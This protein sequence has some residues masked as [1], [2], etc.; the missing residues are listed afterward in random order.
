MRHN[1][2]SV[3]GVWW[4]IRDRARACT[5]KYAHRAAIDKHRWTNWNSFPYSAE[6][7][8]YSTRHV[9]SSRPLCASAV[10]STPAHMYGSARVMGRWGRCIFIRVVLSESTSR[11]SWTTTSTSRKGKANGGQV[12]TC[13][14]QGCVVRFCLYVS[15]SLLLC[16][17]LCVGFCF[18]T[19]FQTTGRSSYWILYPLSGH[20]NLYLSSF[21]SFW[22]E[23][24]SL[25]VHCNIYLSYL[26]EWKDVGTTTQLAARVMFFK[27]VNSL[28]G[29][30]MCSGK[31]KTRKR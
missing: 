16:L 5:C 3:C 6:T 8:A 12:G 22:M 10:T 23:R 7:K 25:F 15:V 21:F 24:V 18:L 4:N 13:D 17:S 11:K 28:W 30:C 29:N 19:I 2:V 31:Q 1:L 27:S 26:R 9:C 14:A 20:L